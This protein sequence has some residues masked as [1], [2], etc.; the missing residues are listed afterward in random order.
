LSHL[1]K[2]W[3]IGDE[4]TQSFDATV[5]SLLSPL[6]TINITDEQWSKGKIE[7]LTDGQRDT[8]G[9]AH[10]A[11]S[12]AI[13]T[14][15]PRLPKIQ[16]SLKSSDYQVSLDDIEAIV[17]I[18]LPV[19]M[20][21][22]SRH[23]A[24][25]AVIR[26]NKVVNEEVKGKGGNYDEIAHS[27]MS[28]QGSEKEP[29]AR[30]A[31]ALNFIPA[32][33]Y[34]LLQNRSSFHIHPCVAIYLAAIL[35]YIAS[36]VIELSARVARDSNY[37]SR[38][39]G[40]KTIARCVELDSE[41]RSL[42][43]SRA[44]LSIFDWTL[45][46]RYTLGGVWEQTPIQP[47]QRQVSPKRLTFPQMIDLS[48]TE[49][50]CRSLDYLL[51]VGPLNARMKVI[52]DGWRRQYY[53]AYYANSKSGA[54]SDSKSAH[55]EARPDPSKIL[56]NVFD[57]AT[58]RTFINARPNMTLY[59][60]TPLP[61]PSSPASTTDAAAVDTKVNALINSLPGGTTAVRYGIPTLMSRLG[62]HERALGADAICGRDQFL[63]NWNQ[64]TC[65][66]FEGFDWS[67]VIVAGGSV[68]SCL[69]PVFDYRQAKTLDFDMFIHGTDQAGCTKKL[70]YIVD[71]LSK[72]SSVVG[73]AAQNRR[74]NGDSVGM[75]T[76]HSITIFCSLKE[77]ETIKQPKQRGYYNRNARRDFQIVLR[78]YHDPAE[79]LLGFDVDSCCVAFD[80]TR[81]LALPRWRRAVT[82][83]LNLVDESRRSTT[84][85]RRLTKYA[86]RGYGV[87]IP[88][89]SSASAGIISPLLWHV[90]HARGTQTGHSGC[91][92][93]LMKMDE[94]ASKSVISR[95]D[96]SVFRHPSWYMK[97]FFDPGQLSE[98]MVY[99]CVVLSIFLGTF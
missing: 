42:F 51:M 47:L 17:Q 76:Q 39:I 80:G 91:L 82:Q 36:E 21:Q 2:R 3:S 43:I 54:G 24:R 87:G 75:R 40:Q 73:E 58:Y 74:G 83:G 65:A 53:R 26:F 37:S 16:A 55:V 7:S 64:L 4:Q 8:I 13:K 30:M 22:H 72:H 50:I 52:E 12:S 90:K 71:W 15:A 92:C 20:S 93:T 84:Y 68:G 57:A 95:N 78:Q 25:Q 97:T 66:V 45:R 49:Y 46:P 63:K 98:T 61:V 23:D 88:G 44:T 29:R 35:E 62:K 14:T 33:I 89:L 5:H 1:R 34:A 77:L 67:N 99:C 56:L 60:A 48:L 31:A 96:W 69:A 10:A 28:R 79:V 85:E 59:P 41:L 32:P 11:L 38:M 27:F 86:H 6:S 18:I 94:K 81:V 70:E 9:K 19:Q